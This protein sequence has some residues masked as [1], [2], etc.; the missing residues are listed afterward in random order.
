M[1]LPILTRDR[2][3][4]AH[5]KSVNATGVLAGGDVT[6]WTPTGGQGFRVR[7][8]ALRASVAGLYE[9]RDGP[10]TVMLTVYLSANAWTTVFTDPIG[11]RSLAPNN[12]LIIRNQSGATADIT[13]AALG[14]EE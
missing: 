11:Y 2:L 7:S 6:L 3:P 4:F 1:P 9:L 12:A 10:A 13:A 5:I 8:V 14:N